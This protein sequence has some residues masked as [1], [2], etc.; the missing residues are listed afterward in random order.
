MTATSEVGPHLTPIHI[1]EAATAFIL[2]HPIVPFQ[3]VVFALH[4]SGATAAMVLLGF[5]VNQLAVSIIFVRKVIR[6]RWR[7]VTG[8]LD[9][10]RGCTLTPYPVREFLGPAHEAID[11]DYAGPAL[12]GLGL[13]TMRLSDMVR[14][15]VIGGPGVISRLSCYYDPL[16]FRSHL[17][18]TD[19]PED[20]RGIQR[21]FILHE[22][23]HS[24]VTMVAA[25]V[26][27]HLGVWPSLMLLAWMA[28][29]APWNLTT[30]AVGIAFGCAV[31]VWWEEWKRGMTELR[32]LDEVVADSFALEHL[33]PDELTRLAR[34]R[35]L[36]MLLDQQMGEIQNTMRLARLRENIDLALKGK[37]ELVRQR[38]FAAVPQARWRLL[39]A[40]AGLTVSAGL[41]GAPPAPGVIGKMAL[42]A[43]VLLV[44]MLYLMLARSYYEH[45]IEQRLREAA[46]AISAPS[47]TGQEPNREI[48][49]TSPPLLDGQG[50]AAAN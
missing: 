3:L 7:L 34:N 5:A 39:L 10:L 38:T 50:A 24:Q 35:S 46:P 40:A 48:Q 33:T 18:I 8:C 42:L 44:W 49:G 6:G 11:N 1:A 25:P 32:A 20:I 22:I 12:R 45:V 4:P 9:R 13:S 37:I 43:A 16:S 30:L 14:I 23:G 2:T 17:F 36:S 28:L 26:T 21:F 27:M 41:C 47:S 15:Y 31:L 19:T 29:T